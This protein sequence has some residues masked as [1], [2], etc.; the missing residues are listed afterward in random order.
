LESARAD[1]SKTIDF[2]KTV[3]FADESKVNILGSDGPEYVWRKKKLKK[4]SKKRYTNSQTW[5]RSRNGLGLYGLRRCGRICN[6]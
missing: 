2:W 1:V 6:S 4:K 3:L 5:R